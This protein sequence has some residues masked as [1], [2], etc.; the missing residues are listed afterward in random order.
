[1]GGMKR[2]SIPRFPS[3]KPSLQVS[4]YMR[5]EALRKQWL[6]PALQNTVRELDDVREINEQLQAF[7][8]P[9]D[10]RRLAEFGLRGEVVFAVPLLLKRNPFLLGYYRLL[11][12]LSQKEFYNKG[13]FGRFRR[14]EDE[15]ELTEQTETLLL[16]LC[17]SLAR[18]AGQ[19]VQG[20]DTI[21]NSVVHELQL[22][23]LG[24][25]LRG[26][27]NN[28]IGDR[29]VKQVYSL[30]HATVGDYASDATARS[31]RV[32]NNSQRSVLID[33]GS[34][35]DVRITEKLQS[36][37]REILSIE[38]KGGGDASNIH[39]R[40]G[41]A[42]KSHLKAKRLGCSEFWTILQVPIDIG[43]AQ[44]RSPTTTRFFHLTRISDPTDPER[45][46]FAEE[47]ASRIGIETAS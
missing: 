29:A 11:Y 30:I 39:N 7:A 22:L 28:R 6:A 38:I 45:S 16:P 35:P 14:L 13:P 21:S 18:I 9:A 33:F 24:P 5:L 20:L 37:T 25:M 17:R 10:L 3:L 41:E 2:Q 4:F 23:T 31:I 34:D 12:G 15:G 42:E 27:E 47:L 26:S 19:L 8:D 46:I 40:L 32:V 44:Q 1:M 43:E 36:G